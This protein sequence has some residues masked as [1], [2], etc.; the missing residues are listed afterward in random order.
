MQTQ[1]TLTQVRQNIFSIA[2]DIV[3]SSIPIKVIH[4]NKP[5]LVIMSNDEYES[6]LETMDVMSDTK[7]VRGIEKAKDEYKRGEHYT[8]EEV[9]GDTDEK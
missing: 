4:K 8:Y 1:Y 6:W 5:S 7:L 2:D 3:A 9:F